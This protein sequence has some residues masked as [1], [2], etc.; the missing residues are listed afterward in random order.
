MPNMSAYI[1]G[2]DLP[3][4]NPWQDDLLG[5]RPFTERLS[6][7]LANLKAPNGYV[8]GLHGEWGQWK[9]NSTKFYQSISE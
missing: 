3:K 4:D 8:V 1:L 6:K 5:F 2:D 7:V 9:I